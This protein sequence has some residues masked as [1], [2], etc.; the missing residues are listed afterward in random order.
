MVCP[1]PI[2]QLPLGRPG[3]AKPLILLARPERFE[4]PTPRFV[5]RRS[6]S[7]DASLLVAV[8]SMNREP[9]PE[10]SLPIA[11]PS[12]LHAGTRKSFRMRHAVFHS[13]RSIG[14][15]PSIGATTWHART[16]LTREK[17]EHAVSRLLT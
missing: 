11:S 3:A 10:T 9:G 12:D 6:S 2:W 14:F 17:R 5:V 15:M 4:R 7:Y 13:H 16:A 1:A 8:P